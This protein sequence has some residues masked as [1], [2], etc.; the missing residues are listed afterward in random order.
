VRWSLDPS[1]ALSLVGLVLL[2]L[3][4]IGIS[5]VIAIICVR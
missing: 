4:L 3:F 1:A 5:A 2:Y